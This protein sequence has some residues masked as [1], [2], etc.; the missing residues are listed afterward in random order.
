MNVP[1]RCAFDALQE[2]YDACGTDRLFE[3]NH[4]V[5]GDESATANEATGCAS[6]PK[7]DDND[8]LEMRLEPLRKRQLMVNALKSQLNDGNSMTD[9]SFE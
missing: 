8:I 3:L 2:V 4:V 9:M 1:R 6:P 7:P 5:N